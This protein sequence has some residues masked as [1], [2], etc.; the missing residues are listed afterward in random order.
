M[1]EDLRKRIEEL[2]HRLRVFL[3]M[4]GNPTFPQ[5][6]FS[7]EVVRILKEEGISFESFDI[8]S[9]EEIRQG[10]KEYSDWPTFPQL[11]VDAAF[12]G[13]CDI[14]VELAQTGELKKLA[15]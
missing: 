15:A 4:K 2:T 6:G 1:N 14:V 5:C 12:I 9:D 7:A 11:Y 8:L 10:V 13:G 3:F